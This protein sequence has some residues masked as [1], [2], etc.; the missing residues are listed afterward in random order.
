MDSEISFLAFLL[1]A[2]PD[3]APPELPR[4]REME[5]QC[6]SRTWSKRPFISWLFGTQTVFSLKSMF[7]RVTGLLGSPCTVLSLSLSL[8]PLADTSTSESSLSLM[9]PG[10]LGSWEGCL[11]GW[12]ERSSQ[13]LL[14]GYSSGSAE[15][16]C[17]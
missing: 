3:L 2:S 13:L 14:S 4:D 1:M 17:K 7:A 16:K 15:F 9:A 5:P 11:Q 6:A 8:S 12:W 10:H